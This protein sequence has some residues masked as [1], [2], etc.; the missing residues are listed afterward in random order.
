MSAGPPAAPLAGLRVVVPTS[1]GPRALAALLES[2]GARVDEAAWIVIAP[3]SQPQA[4]ARAAVRWCA[5]DYAWMAVTSRN[6]IAGLAAAAR[7]QGCALAQAQP[8]ALVAALGATT[9][10]ACEREGLQVSLV[11]AREASARGLAAEFPDAGPGAGPVLAPVGDR[12]D[13][14]L[15]EA[16]EGKGWRVEQ[17]EAYRTL[18]GP[19]PEPAVLQDLAAGLVDAVVLTSGSVAERLSESVPALPHGTMV[20]AIGAVTA[21]AAAGLGIPVAAVAARPTYEATV[22]ALMDAVGKGGR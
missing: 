12:V 5:G 15:A 9:R 17:V 10:A 1:P 22:E 3:S 14:S 18:P 13:G 6:G 8:P 7:P 16:L 4:L 2:R 19:G 20:V 11:P 21:A